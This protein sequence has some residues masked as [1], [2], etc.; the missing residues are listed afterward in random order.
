M[1]WVTRSMSRPVERGNPRSCSTPNSS[2]TTRLRSRA[3]AP[4]SVAASLT[5][6]HVLAVAPVALRAPGVVQPFVRGC[7]RVRLAAGT[8]WWCILEHRATQEGADVGRE[9]RLRSLLCVETLN[10]A[11]FL[12]KM[13]T[14]FDRATVQARISVR[15]VMWHIGARPHNADAADDRS[16]RQVSLQRA[17]GLPERLG[18]IRLGPLAGGDPPRGTAWSTGTS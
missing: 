18:G 2:S 5:A 1:D 8:V 14:D 6:T 9:P 4:G 16:A 10:L 11:A 13:M 17:Q 3:G 12:D 15:D 7:R